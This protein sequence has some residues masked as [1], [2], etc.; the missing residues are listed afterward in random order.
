MR[1]PRPRRL[2]NPAASSGSRKSCPDCVFEICIEKG[3]F[4]QSR[5][6]DVSNGKQSGPRIG[7]E[8]GPLSD[9]GTGLSR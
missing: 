2:R 8:K 1:V 7:M 4:H 6:L 5:Y 3:Q 9:L